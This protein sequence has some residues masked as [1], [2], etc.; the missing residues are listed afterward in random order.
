MSEAILEVKDLEKMYPGGVHAVRGVNFKVPE[1]ICFGLLGPNGAGKSTT[2]EMIEGIISATHGEV[3]YRGKPIGKH[4]REQVGIQFQSTALQDFIKV[5]ETLD[6]F[7]SFYEKTMPKEEI[8]KICS[9]EDLRARDTKKLSGGQRQRVLLA[10]ALINDPELIFLD[11]PTTGLDPA[12]RRNFWTLVESIK[13]KGKTIIL[14]THYMDEA[15]ALCDDIAIMNEG[16]IIARGTPEALVQS[17]FPGVW[18]ELKIDPKNPTKPD[19]SWETQIHGDTMRV[20]TNN[21]ADTL[22][23][24]IEQKYN[25]EG[26]KVS[27]A[28][29]EDLFIDLTGSELRS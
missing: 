4:F 10:L 16:K 3:L 6:L 17:R 25:L 15:H 8:I 1:G 5:E 19:W 20:L 23:K 21:T 18:V 29:L 24:C 14:T 7:A 2:I 28:T 12:A 22:E 11:E 9:L 13:A 26:L 27:S